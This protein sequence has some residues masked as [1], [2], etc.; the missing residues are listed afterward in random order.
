MIVV[1]SRAGR[2][3][4]EVCSV[5]SFPCLAP[6]MVARGVQGQ[7]IEPGAKSA[8]TAKRPDRLAELEA[9]RLRDILSITGITRPTPG[10]RV[11]KII[12]LFDEQAEGVSIAL[13]RPL[14]KIL[15]QITRP[16]LL[17]LVLRR[18][19]LAN[20]WVRTGIIF[21]ILEFSALSR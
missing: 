15:V 9:H 18:L 4:Q 17:Q 8:S 1:G 6:L 2:V 21:T 16:D 7:R 13:L 11:D 3:G 14:D 12:V 19:A 5:A 20:P 10:N